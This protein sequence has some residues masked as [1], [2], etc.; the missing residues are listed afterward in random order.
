MIG[1][2]IRG[3][4]LPWSSLA[5]IRSQRCTGYITLHSFEILM[6]VRSDYADGATVDSAIVEISSTLIPVYL[7][8]SPD[9]PEHSF[10]TAKSVSG[11]VVNSCRR[12]NKAHEE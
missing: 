1:R 11:T 12:L 5:R 10:M 7:S 6:L 3:C 4:M 2:C 9:R 8:L